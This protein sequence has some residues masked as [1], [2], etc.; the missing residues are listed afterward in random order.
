MIEF[1][2]IL[3]KIKWYTEQNLIIFWELKS[4]L[5]LHRINIQKRRVYT[6]YY[7][8][9]TIN[10]W[11]QCYKCR[12]LYRGHKIF[13]IIKVRTIVNLIVRSQTQTHYSLLSQGMVYVIQTKN[14]ELSLI[15]H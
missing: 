6:I 10:L 2:D 12:L 3:I 7:A 9:R 13:E 5:T 4:G 14:V 8:N 11:I 1:H 15:R